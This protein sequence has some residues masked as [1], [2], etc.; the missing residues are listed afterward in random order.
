MVEDIRFL[1]RFVEGYKYR[2]I[3]YLFE[4]YRKQGLDLFEVVDVNLKNN[5]Y[6]IITPPV[7]EKHGNSY[8]LIEGNTRIFYALK[9]DIKEVKCVVIEGVEAPIPSKGNFRKKDL[10]LIDKDLRGNTRFPDFDLEGYRKIEE[11]VR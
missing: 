6:T 7:I 8:I 5:N 4:V 9:N 11:A 2:Q 10:L 3:Q 1:I